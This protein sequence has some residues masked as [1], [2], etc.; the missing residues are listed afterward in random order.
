MSGNMKDSLNLQSHDTFIC[1]HFCLLPRCFTED[2][3][4]SRFYVAACIGFG[5]DNL[6]FVLQN[7]YSKENF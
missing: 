2:R 6:K 3:S 1:R 4:Y 7:V 5:I